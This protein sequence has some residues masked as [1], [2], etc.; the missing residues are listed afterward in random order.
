MSEAQAVTG[1]AGRAPA[2]E[3]TGW[4]QQWTTDGPEDL[5]RQFIAWKSTWL[6]SQTPD[7]IDQANGA[8]LM[9]LGLMRSR[10]GP[11]VF[12]VAG[13]GTKGGRCT[14]KLRRD[15]PMPAT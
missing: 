7:V 3:R 6:K 2:D 5:R 10:K 15:P 8:L 13:D 14:V 4:V 12:D 9:A 1:D 11:Y